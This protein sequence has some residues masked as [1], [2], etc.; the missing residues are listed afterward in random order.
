M[1]GARPRLLGT[2]EGIAMLTSE[3]LE[4]MESQL[5]AEMEAEEEEAEMRLWA[6]AVV[7][8]EPDPAGEVALAA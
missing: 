5:W 4:K 8:D 7:Y 6:C 2:M 3:Y 1:R